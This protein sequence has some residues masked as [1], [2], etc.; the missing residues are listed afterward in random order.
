MALRSL[1]AADMVRSFPDSTDQR[2]AGSS[3]VLFNRPDMTEGFQP[4]SRRRV[5]AIDGVVD[6]LLPICTGNQ[7]LGCPMGV[8]FWA[9][10]SRPSP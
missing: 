7:S 4:F 10:S 8:F 2:A 6:F 5:G 3:G 9:S 1:D